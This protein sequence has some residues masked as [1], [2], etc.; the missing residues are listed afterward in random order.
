MSAQHPVH[1][2]R[3]ALEDERLKLVEEL[4]AKGLEATDIIK[5]LAL[6]QAALTA[7]RDEIEEHSMHLGGGGEKELP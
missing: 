7:V 5:Q 1:S 6:V 2:L 4:A 3:N